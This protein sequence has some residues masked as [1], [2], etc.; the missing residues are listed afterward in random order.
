MAKSNI[1]AD[2]KAM[3]EEETGEGEKVMKHKG[4]G[5]GKLAKPNC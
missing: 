4:K 5:K 3:M 2:M 1:K